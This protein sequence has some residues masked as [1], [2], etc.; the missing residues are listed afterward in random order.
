MGQV[1]LV[2]D[3]FKFFKAA[4]WVESCPRDWQ[5]VVSMKISQVKVTIVEFISKNWNNDQTLILLNQVLVKQ[6]ENDNSSF[7]KANTLVAYNQGVKM[8]KYF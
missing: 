8:E 6:N 7:V 1:I 2:T 5:S 4:I 3:G